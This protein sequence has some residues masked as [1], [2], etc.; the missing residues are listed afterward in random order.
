MQRVFFV[1]ARG[2]LSRFFLRIDER[3]FFVE[4]HKGNCVFSV[5]GRPRDGCFCAQRMIRGLRV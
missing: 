3:F 2:V 4:Q 1:P 5:E